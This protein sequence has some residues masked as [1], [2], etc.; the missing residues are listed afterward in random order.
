MG[1]LQPQILKSP[2]RQIPKLLNS[3]IA[4]SNR[5]SISQFL[6][7]LNSTDT[8]VF[9]FEKLFGRWEGDTLVVE[10]TNFNGKSSFQGATAN[11]KLT[12]RFTRIGPNALEYRFTIDDP[13]IW[14]RPWTGMF[15]WDKDDDQYEL[16]E[17]ACH[18]ANYGMTNILAG[19]RVTEKERAKTAPAAPARK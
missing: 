16:V 3:Q 13:T 18:E 17:Y 9:D 12:E 6:N 1:S 5:S 19:A 11:M 10:T 7:S 15:V 14:T 8:K 4:Q 2:N